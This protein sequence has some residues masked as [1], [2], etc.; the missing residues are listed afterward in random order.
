ML[1]QRFEMPHRIRPETPIRDALIFGAAG[2][3]LGGYKLSAG[4]FAKPPHA[5]NITGI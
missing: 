2:A 1:M 4:R 5:E 3:S